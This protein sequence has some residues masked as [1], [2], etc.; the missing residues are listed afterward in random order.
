[1]A[2]TQTPLEVPV[3]IV[4]GGGAGL[5]CSM[6]LTQLGVETLLVNALPTTSILPKA[7]VLNQRA[8]EILGDVGVADEIYAKGTP[9][10]N[11]RAT[12]FYAGLAGNRPEHG[13]RLARLE[14]WGAGGTDTA[15]VS[16]SP[17]IQTNLPQIRLEPVLRRG[18]EAAA[19]IDRVRFHHELTALE[20]DDDGVTATIRDLDAGSEYQVRSR[21][22]LACDG[23]RTVGRMLGVELEGVRG[24]VDECSIHMSA[25]LSKWATDDDVLI[26]WIWVPETGQLA[27]LV[28]MGPERWG[29]KSEEWV[30]HLNYTNDD[31][32]ALDDDRVIADMRSALGIG[33]HPITV[34]KVSRWSLDGVVAS[35][36]KVGRVMMVG[37]AAHR[38][39]P[40]GGLGLTSAIHDAHNVC[41]KMASVLRGL[42]SPALLDTYEPERK[43]VDARNV[44]RSLE[45]AFNHWAIAEK[46]GLRQSPMPDENWAALKKALGDDP[47]DADAARAA[48]RAFATQTMEFNEHN[49]EYGYTHVSSAVVPDGSDPLPN[50]DPI[51]LYVPST[52]PGHPLP[53]AWIED[54]DG[55]RVST[56]DVVRP[57]RFVLL[58]GEGG[59]AWKEAALA[60]AAGTGLPLDAYT[61]GHT[62]G[63][64][65]D[66]QCHWTRLR[67]HAADGA[68]LVR[69]DRCV[70]W[71]ATS[72][73]A[74]PKAA[75]RTALE[76]VLQ[77]KLVA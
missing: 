74:D 68:I 53:H 44:Q 3:L 58:A 70:A 31:P 17:R 54:G 77:R 73:A 64:L 29:T 1:M 12:A 56:L 42:A 71:R 43:P 41:W 69:P 23:G 10:E 63:D 55:R 20:Q 14:C 48:R 33:E 76:Q 45:N 50:P 16:A 37:D 35:K 62:D 11:M 67:E 30:F 72:A 26:R 65:L 60:L 59:D 27:V 49:V 22:V 6:L 8:M 57:G 21:Y 9:A 4:G 38:H 51:R 47:A 75:L 46:I 52:R 18:A 40:T 13:R 66:L 34:H 2:S 28:P 7:H 36:F 19:G 15:W 24:M 61:L 5:T 39:P 25:D 32:R